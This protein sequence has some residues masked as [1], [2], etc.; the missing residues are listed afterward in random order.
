MNSDGQAGHKGTTA[1]RSSKQSKAKRRDRVRTWAQPSPLGHEWQALCVDQGTARQ[2]QIDRR[3][4]GHAG[5]PTGF[6]RH[7]QHARACKVSDL[8]PHRGALQGLG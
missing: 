1:S 6:P 7:W 4:A 3:S 8:P 2:E 5:A